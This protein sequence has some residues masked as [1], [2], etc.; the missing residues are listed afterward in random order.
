MNTTDATEAIS[1]DPP[2][3][4]F[5]RRDFRLGEWLSAPVTPLFA[6]WFLPRFEE[7]FDGQVQR[8]LGARVHLPLH[9]LVNGW[10]YTNIGTFD[11][12]GM[13]VLRHPGYFLR[14][15]RAMATFL[16]NPGRAERDIA[17]PA[18]VLYFGEI[19]PA[20]GQAIAEAETLVARGDRDDLTTAVDTVATAAGPLL[21]S[22]A[23]RLGFGAKAELALF[24]LYDRVLRPRIGGSHQAL[25][26][27]LVEPR[28]PVPH[29]VTSIDWAF[30]TAGDRPAAAV[31]HSAGHATAVAAREAA[32]RA[33][34]DALVAS[35]K[36]LARFERALAIAQ[37]YAVVREEMVDELTLGWPV[38]RRAVIAIGAQLEADGWLDEPND[39]FF[40][41][42][43]EVETPTGALT[44][45][46]AAR[47]A[48]WERQRA[49]AA[50]ITVGKAK[51]TFAKRTAMA[52]RELV[53][54]LVTAP[55]TVQGFPASAGTATGTARIVR[56]V[57]DFDR[58]AVGDVLIAPITAPA[59]TPLFADAAAVVT[60]GGSL[61]AHASI[62]AREY[63]IPAV[64]GTEHAT[65]SI[66]DG[67]TVTVDG[68][69]GVVRW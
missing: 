40:C 56:D 62:I 46:I 50:P 36:D 10:Y 43:T 32:E 12:M 42:R 41:L 58:L 53:P 29:A 55:R 6:D 20:Y 1:W 11:G 44:E 8:M 48:E 25:L 54:E 15:G 63:G 57:G 35:P 13:A 22:M 52:R 30:P 69:T 27:G 19:L 61:I 5:W 34:R 51:G 49:L 64:V 28:P 67:V 4:G 45:R 7:G 2:A 66:P 24:R 17:Q 31:D 68:T 33:C 21:Y 37:R 9:V 3:G 47:R 26:A 59:W 60:D 65:S 14:W 18:G 16:T 23:E 38:M 39:V